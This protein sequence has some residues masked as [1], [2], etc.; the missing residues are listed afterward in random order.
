MDELVCK[1]GIRTA[2]IYMIVLCEN[3]EPVLPRLFCGCYATRMSKLPSRF[4]AKVNK[5]DTC[6][7]WTGGL[8]TAGYGHVW[9]DGRSQLAHRASYLASG[10]SIPDGMQLDHKCR[11]R[12]C[13]RPDHLEPVTSRENSA[14][15]PISLNALNTMKETCPQGHPYD[16]V[17]KNG[18][19]GCVA[20]DRVAVVRGQARKRGLPEPQ[21]VSRADGVVVILDLCPAGHEYHMAGG[22]RWCPP[23]AAAKASARAA[24]RTRARQAP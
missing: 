18:R 11:V 6:W 17:R 14:R 10:R 23:C 21:L 12:T 15:S 13:V 22:R 5:T 24:E 1:P 8:Q 20:C 16:I 4:W 2:V 9:L 7:L 3:L 19:R